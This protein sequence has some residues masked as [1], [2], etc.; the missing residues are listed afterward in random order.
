MQIKGWKSKAVSQQYSR[1]SP[2]PATENVSPWRLFFMIAIGIFTAEVIAMVA[3]YFID[4]IAYYQTTL[5]DAGIIVTLIFPFLYFLSFRPLVQHIEM[6]RQAEQTLRQKEELQ[7]RFFN[8][9][10]IMIAYMDRDFN[11]IKVNDAYAAS[12]GI[13]GPDYFVGKNHFDLFPHRENQELFQ[14]VV[15]TGEAY[16]VFEKPFE[17]P[18]QPERGVTYWNWSVQPVMEPDGR[19]DGL[20]LSL[21]DVTERKRAEEEAELERARLRSILDAM[22]DGVYM[23]NKYFDVE[24]TNPVIEREFGAVGSQ[25]CYTYFHDR[26]EVC[27]W[28]K[29]P[30]VFSGRSSRWEWSSPKTGKIYDVFDTPLTN[31]DGSISKLKLMHDISARKK[32]QSELEQRN[33]ELQAVSASEHKQRQVAETLRLA[34]QALTQSLDLDTVFRTL[35]QHLR[36][37]VQA[38]TASAIFPEGESQLAVRAVEGYENWTDP[39]KLLSVKI[40]RDT[41]PILQKLILTRSTY[42]IQNTD[43]DPNWTDYPG[44]EPIHSRIFV[45][46]N[47]DEKLIGVVG[48]GKFETNY[49]TE[50]HIQWAEALIG[51]AAIAIQNAWLFEQVRAGRERLQFLSHRLV[52]VQE[53]ER[54]FIARELHDHAGQTLTSLMLGLGTIEKAAGKPDFVQKRA[55]ELKSLTDHVLEDLHRLAVN[56]RPASLD[57]LGLT[58]A[59]EQFIK[60]FTQD[61]R[62][63]IKLKTVGFSEDERL[64]QEIETALYRIVQEAL[65]NVV[66]HAKANRVD[67][68]LERLDGSLLVIVEDDGQGFD[69]NLSRESGHLGLLGMQERVEMLG[70]TLTVESQPGQGTTL[71]VEVPYDHTDI[72]RG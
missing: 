35:I 45:P 60:T 37:L 61:T 3:V 67:V 72:A 46:I 20:V 28:C 1:T 30:D 8:S 5:I 39:F 19:V 31:V 71:F 18:D 38:D 62:L 21:L 59:L 41:H 63:P 9:I 47:V 6:R 68:V 12:V 54:R 10:G 43:E 65:T 40:D 33:L 27:E 55:G 52:E 14:R 48:L 44:T 16:S 25:K 7:H 32:A 66:R 17:Y 50:E 51:Q 70:G 26:S 64:P 36:A 53:T 13:N 58:P 69:V 22:P 34:A 11:F 29:N 15:D 56:L 57:H 42:V 24:Y 23:V 49:F 4:P 2:I